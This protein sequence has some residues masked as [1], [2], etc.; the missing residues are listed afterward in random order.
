MCRSN[1]IFFNEVS[2]KVRAV[3]CDG[4]SLYH[5]SAPVPLAAWANAPHGTRH[6]V[7]TPG[8]I[9]DCVSKHSYLRAFC[10][11]PRHLSYR[12]V[13]YGPLC[14]PQRVP[15]LRRQAFLPLVLLR[16]A[17]KA[18]AAC[19]CWGHGWPRAVNAR[20]NRVM[21]CNRQ[22]APPLPSMT[23]FCDP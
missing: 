20:C 17:E 8:V 22:H 6:G 14:P 4:K 23:S 12:W 5:A 16:E 7:A 10:S 1:Y 18:V 19:S 11:C 13:L 9:L 21:L 3:R 15:G 2:C